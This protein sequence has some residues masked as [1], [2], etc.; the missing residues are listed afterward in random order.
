[1]RKL[2]GYT[3]VSPDLSQRYSTIEPVAS[4]VGSSPYPS[5]A[6]KW[7]EQN[8]ANHGQS[9]DGHMP[10]VM[11]PLGMQGISNFE[12]TSNGAMPIGYYHPQELGSTPIYPEMEAITE[13]GQNHGN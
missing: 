4:S 10:I 2:A 9:A 7:G 6:Y 12:W 1:M 5:G 8:A 11:A 3:D 13:T